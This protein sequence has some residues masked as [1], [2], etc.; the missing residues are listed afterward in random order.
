MARGY[1]E[2][3]R[4]GARIAAIVT[5]DPGQNAAMA[6]KLALP[7][8]ILSDPDG[9]GAIKPHGVWDETRNIAR[10]AV[11]VRAPDGREVFRYVGVDFMDRPVDD[12]VLAALDD[13]RLPPLDAVTAPQPHLEPAPGPRALPLRDLAVY[14]RGVRF[15]MQATAGRAR[16]PWDR[17][18][19][20][21]TSEMAERFMVA[22]GATLRIVGA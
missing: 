17:A 5:D 7:F 14:M 9:D 3:A 1:E 6:A 13:L 20:E 19:A 2:Y 18:E 21:R 12:D 16:D 10:P 15:A 8:A 4:R 22:Q 11:V